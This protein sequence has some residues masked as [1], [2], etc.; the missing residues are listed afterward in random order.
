MRARDCMTAVWAA[1]A[2][3]LAPG[4][5]PAQAQAGMTR[6]PTQYIAALGMVDATSGD[7]AQTWGLWAVDPGPRGVRMAGYADMVADGGRAPEG[8]RFDPAA[9]WIEEHGLLMETPSF[10]VPA[11]RYVVT[12]G[13][14]VM[15]ILTVEAPDASGRQRWSLADGATLHDVT[16]LGCRAAVYTPA[17]TGAA[18]TPDRT[19]MGA[20]PMRPDIAMPEVEGCAKKDYA[21]LIVVGMMGG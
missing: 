2:L 6:I 21:V 7:D 13:R 14:T 15:S 17:R 9:W 19:P 5:A 1:L 8:W 3:T 16:H 18:C 11:G 20:F 10:P 12:G 4:A